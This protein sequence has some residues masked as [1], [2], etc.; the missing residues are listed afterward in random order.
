MYLSEL[1]LHDTSRSNGDPFELSREL[2][3]TDAKERIDLTIPAGFRTD[4]ASIPRPFRNIISKVGR[5]MRGAVV[6]DYLYRHRLHSGD[7]CWLAVPKKKA[8]R[9]FKRI[10]EHDEVAGWKV[11]MMYNAVRFGGGWAYSPEKP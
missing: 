2:R 7:W 4:L 3:Y 11:W 6:H 5:H 9:I 8:D 1:Y 10:M